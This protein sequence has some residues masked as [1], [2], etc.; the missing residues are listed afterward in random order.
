MQRS[1]LVAVVVAAAAVAIGVIAQLGDAAPGVPTRATAL[2]APWLVMAFALGALCRRSIGGALA[3]AVA[4]SGGTFVY[5]AVQLA[6]TGHA[7]AVATG[8]IALS[9]ASAAV[10]AGAAMG[11]IGTVWRRATGPSYLRALAAA[12]PAAA[13]VG[14]AILLAG[15]WDGRAAVALPAAE[16]VLAAALLPACARRRAPVVGAVLASAVLAVAFAAGESEVRDAM[17]TVGWAGA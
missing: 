9:W 1:V 8:V 3:G 12:S 13:L 6:I 4:L 11:A 2:G 14:E 10:G 17:R 5:Y 16:L 15:E 7:R